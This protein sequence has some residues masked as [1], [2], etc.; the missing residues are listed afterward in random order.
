MFLCCPFC[1]FTFINLSTSI[2]PFCFNGLWSFKGMC[3]FFFYFHVV[4]NEPLCFSDLFLLQIAF[5]PFCS[6]NL[7]NSMDYGILCFVLVFFLL[8]MFW[9]FNEHLCFN[10]PF[11]FNG[12]L[13]VTSVFITTRATVHY[14]LCYSLLKWG[15]L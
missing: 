9:F 15:Y 6:V 10:E 1:F 11:Y 13:V 12:V 7:S 3:W 5:L 2:N 14:I 4:L 8:S